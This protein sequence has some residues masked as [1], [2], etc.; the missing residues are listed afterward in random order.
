MKELLKETK[1]LW[2]Y[3]ATTEKPIILYGM[4]NGADKI[5]T[6]LKTV[7]KEPQGV[8]A[9][10]EFV[11]GQKYAGYTVQKYADINEQ[12]KD[13]IILLAF[14]T[15]GDPLLNVF[16]ELA[17]KHEVYAPHLP[18]YE[19]EECV[20]SSWL[21][22]YA[23]ELKATYELLA[24]DLSK[25][26]FLDM[27][28]YKMSGKLN[29]LFDH[30]TERKSDIDTLFRFTTEEIYVDLGAYD[31]D[32]IREFLE[33]CKDEYKEIIALEPDRKNYKKLAKYCEANNLKNIEIL[34]KGIWNS[35]G[36]ISFSN[37][38]GRQSSI[39]EEGKGTIEVD[40]LDNIMGARQATYIKMDVEGVEF[41]ALTGGVKQL[42][43]LPNLLLAA[44]HH[45]EDLFILPFKLKKIAPEY[46]I[47]L[48]KHKYVP[49]WEINFFCKK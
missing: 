20:S 39:L 11:R 29:Y 6:R 49:A 23:E 7:G 24:D 43:N 21:E 28:N 46:K 3:L 41:E 33:C 35:A 47:Y 15:E 34:N 2:E 38:G 12:Y 42:A 17:E 37:S 9:S 26:V 48:R 45:D 32:T 1:T 14:A 10:D 4:G 8:F 30:E 13:F 44:Y 19:G 22:Q 25:E 18:I 5:I 40:S 31:G 36:E 27:L 16:K